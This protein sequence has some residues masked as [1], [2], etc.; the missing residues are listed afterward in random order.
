MTREGQGGFEWDQVDTAEELDKYVTVRETG[1][2]LE[3]V[4]IWFDSQGTDKGVEDQ[5]G[6]SRTPVEDTI[7]L[8]GVGTGLGLINS[9][10][11]LVEA[12]YKVEV[13][14]D[15]HWKG[16]DYSNDIS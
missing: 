1:A 16:H 4:T 7:I 6:D 13:L 8:V 10:D 2:N 5:W 15:G 9:L 14:S 11:D 12:N 3:N